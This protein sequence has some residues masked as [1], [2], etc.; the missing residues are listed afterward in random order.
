MLVGVD[1]LLFVVNADA[2]DRSAGDARIFPAMDDEQ[3]TSGTRA[4]H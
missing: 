2:R 3:P 1:Q 4:T